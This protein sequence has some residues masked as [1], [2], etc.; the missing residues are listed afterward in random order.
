M[1]GKKQQLPVQAMIEELCALAGA[2]ATIEDV[3][4]GERARF[5]R[6]EPWPED[7]TELARRER[8]VEQDGRCWRITV[9]QDIGDRV[10]AERD[11]RRYQAIVEAQ[12]DW[13]A[14]QRP[15]GR[16]TFVN[17]V[18]CRWMGMSREDLLGPDY[19]GLD[20]V[21]DPADL[22]RFHANRAAL[23]PTRPTAVNELRTRHPDG[24]RRWEQWTDTAIFDEA[25]S[26]VEYQ[27][28]GREITDRVLAEDAL[29]ASE[30]R[31]RNVVESQNDLITRVRPDGRAT[32]VNDAYCRYMGMSREQ[33]L[34]PAWDDLSPLSP[35]HRAAILAEWAAMT[36]QS[37]NS[38]HETEVILPGGRRRIE[39]WSQLGIF[40]AHGHLLE[41]QGVGRDVT[42]QREAERALQESEERYRAVVEDLTEVVGRY[43]AD[44]KL[45]FANGAHARFA[46][47]SSEAMFGRDLFTDVPPA[48]AP[49]LRERLLALTPQAPIYVGE[50][51]WCTA[52][53]KVRS[54]HWTNRALFDAAGRLIGYQ[55]VGRDITELKQTEAALREREA[56]LSTIIETQTEW[57]TRE[58][59]ENRYIFVN[60]AYCRYKGMTAE[61][62]C[63]P[64]YN[65]Y[66]W[67]E[68]EDHVRFKTLR[69]AM[70]PQRP[71]YTVELRVRMPDGSRRVEEWTETAIFGPGGRRVG[72]QSVGRD[73]SELK[74]AESALRER[75]AFLRAII[76]TQTEWVARQDSSGRFTFVNQAYCRYMGM[77]PEEFSSPDYDDWASMVPD[78]RD[79]FKAMRAAV[80]PDRPT[81]TM[82][83][84]HRHPDGSYRVEEWTETTI[85]DEFGAIQAYQAVGRD[86]TAQRDAERQ[87]QRQREQLL[88]QEKLA[89]LGSLLAGVAHELNNPLSVVVG[90][91]ALLRED[92]RDKAIRESVKQIHAAAQRCARIVST[93]LAMARQKPPSF[94]PVDLA[95]CVEEALEIVG[96][97]LRS[98]GV[99][100]GNLIPTDLPPVHADA[101][102]LHQVVT[103]LVIN[104]QQ[105]LMAR[106]EPR[107]IE[108]G[109]ASM[110]GMV[111]LTIADNGPGIPPE[112]HR[113]VFEPFFTTKPQGV[114]T[115][116]GLA[117]CHGI[118]TTHRGSID[119][120][121]PP[122]GGTVVRVRL[123]VA[124]G[125]KRR[126]R[127]G[128]PK[129]TGSILIVDDEPGIVSSIG[130]ALRRDGHRV[131]VASEGR[132]A[133]HRLEQ[134]GIDLVITDLR[135]PGMDGMTLLD[136]MRAMGGCLAETAL[137]MTGDTLR[138]AAD[139]TLA[140]YGDRV[141]EKPVDL[142]V[143]RRRVRRSLARRKA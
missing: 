6:A 44:F 123:P 122:S 118:L 80:T 83:L 116:L 115:G 74:R 125:A 86:L 120:D 124:E 40:D 75:E 61:E 141:I 76:E 107:R 59:L 72:Y 4:T 7:G 34:D 82:E 105:A 87:I 113:R 94:G 130:E 16:L 136:R 91:A 62:L 85:F 2:A 103:N 13:I 98:G 92:A 68:P 104:A 63:A 90:Y 106:P 109:A 139:P 67:V 50:N 36:P 97:P 49:L 18:Y 19:A 53:G 29:R 134:G 78:D 114:G 138:A 128:A 1:A 52:E 71:T 23:S 25:G 15:D 142:A 32:F 84:R 11:R 3:T 33:L 5:G 69:D 108:I 14:R 24:S 35:E 47:L 54:F 127:Q 112:L 8:L 51:D 119:L 17:D 64:D 57:V 117:V 42:E 121:C 48:V 102:Q 22:A 73:V 129:A 143:L 55:A 101:D 30:G 111:E 99:A 96:Y 39:Q 27:L 12:T 79:R 45:T 126:A 100:V 77:T 26:I 41:V 65:D 133:L 10:A 88:Q 140:G 93:F 37:P 81:F 28:V 95:G 60:Q 89:A 38:T 43:D 135:M 66:L 21:D 20:L 58:S 137:I 131:E 46:G 110:D 31:Y 9:E 56:L 70:T 132:S